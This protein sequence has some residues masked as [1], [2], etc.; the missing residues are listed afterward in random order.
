MTDSNN[1]LLKLLS[2]HDYNFGIKTGKFHYLIHEYESVINNYLLI[3]Y[4]NGV[5]CSNLRSFIGS[6][7]GDALKSEGII[8]E[9]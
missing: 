9:K 4:F 7:L 1:S 3:S 2:K 5:L 8:H 6:G